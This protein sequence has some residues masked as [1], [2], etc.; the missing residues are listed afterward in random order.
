MRRRLG[1]ILPGNKIL[2][3]ARGSGGLV[4]LRLPLCPITALEMEER[5]LAFYR[6]CEIW[7][8]SRDAVDEMIRAY[9]P[10]PEPESVQKAIA[11]TWQYTD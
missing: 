9:W 11:A 5:T 3:T 8:V 4:V 7:R 1:I 10:K 2:T 6:L